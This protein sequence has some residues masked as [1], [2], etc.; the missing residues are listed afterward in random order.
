MAR[1]A[2][3]SDTRS[4]T[5]FR[6]RMRCSATRKC[7]K[8]FKLRQHPDSYLQRWRVACPSCGGPAYADEANR[9]REY[10]KRLD[11]GR[12]C[13]CGGAPFRHEVGSIRGC[14]HHA[15]AD[16]PFTK[17]EEDDAEYLWRMPRSGNG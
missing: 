16:V 2:F 3:R 15:L 4:T 10:Q 13:Q 11:S 7:G 8:R 14:E 6:F 1:Q 5:R 9:Q 12:V 17:E